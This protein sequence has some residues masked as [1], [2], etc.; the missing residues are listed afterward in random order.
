MA[1]YR[2]FYDSRHLQADYHELGSALEPNAWQS[3][4][5]YLYHFS[6]WQNITRPSCAYAYADDYM[7]VYICAFIYVKI[8]H[9][10]TNGTCL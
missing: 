7:E 4:M 3:S 9:L 5:G 10:F 1:A 6:N 2:R 8:G